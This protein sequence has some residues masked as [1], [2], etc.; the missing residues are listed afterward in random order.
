MY[1]T[2]NTNNENKNIRLLSGWEMGSNGQDAEMGSI[3]NGKKW[4]EKRNGVSHHFS[5]SMIL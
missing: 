2:K 1:T 4:K 3:R 5:I